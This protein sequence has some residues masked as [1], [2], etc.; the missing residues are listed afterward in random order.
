MDPQHWPKVSNSDPVQNPGGLVNL[1]P[2]SDQVYVA[3]K[4][5]WTFKLQEKPPALER[6]HS[7]PQNMNFFMDHLIWI[8]YTG[9]LNHR[10]KILKS[11]CKIH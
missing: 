4:N 7:T 6:E 3:Q 8:Y 9:L 10:K 1:V 2:N 11:I 5:P